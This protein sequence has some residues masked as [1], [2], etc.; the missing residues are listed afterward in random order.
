[1]GGRTALKAETVGVSAEDRLAGLHGTLERL[2]DELDRLVLTTGRGEELD[3]DRL[4]RSLELAY[5][6]LDQVPPVD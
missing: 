2:V 5:A 1:M 3:R 4:W 6:A